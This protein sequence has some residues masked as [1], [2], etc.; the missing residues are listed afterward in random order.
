MVNVCLTW[1]LG[2]GQN[3]GM[4]NSHL[5]FWI[6]AIGAGLFFYEIHSIDGLEREIAVWDSK[7]HANRNPGAGS[8]LEA[9]FDGATLGIFSDGDMFAVA[10]KL[11]N[12]SAELEAER[13]D[14]LTRYQQAVSYRN[15]GLIGCLG[16]LAVGFYFRK[17]AL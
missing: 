17:K 5:A 7:L 16:G 8:F 10:H 11:E 3:R 14:L 1:I 4:K 15:W 2:G 9:F 12:E 13:V 6:A